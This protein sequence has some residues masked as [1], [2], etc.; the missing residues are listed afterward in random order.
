MKRDE[1]EYSVKEKS[2]HLVELFQNAAAQKNII[3]KLKRKPKPVK[4]RNEKL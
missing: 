1:T 4:H 3:L 2:S